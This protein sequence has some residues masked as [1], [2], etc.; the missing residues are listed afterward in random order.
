MSPA[1]PPGMPWGVLVAAYFVLVGLVSGLALVGFRRRAR[2]PWRASRADV[3]AVWLS[4]GA[5]VLCGLLLVADLGRPERFFLMLTRFDTLGSPL[6]VGAKVLALK[7]ALLAVDLYLLRRARGADGVRPPGDRRTALLWRA[8]LAGTGLAAVV[9]AAYPAVVLDLTWGAP[10]A[11]TG[12]AM[13][14]LLLTAVLLGVAV[15]A[16]LDAALPAPGAAPGA[17]LRGPLAAC[18][19]GTVVVVAF[20]G[21]SARGDPRAWTALAGSGWS[22]TTAGWVAAVAGLAVAAAA[23]PFLRRSRALAAGATAAA[24]SAGAVRLLIVVTG[25]WGGT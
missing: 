3:A 23:V 13:A 14:V 21:W 15:H 16:V 25:A 19:A 17:D 24:V 7:T 9:L 4:F 5:S 2:R 22:P 18:L 20:A 10:L 6:S 12:G 1:L 8:V 11:G